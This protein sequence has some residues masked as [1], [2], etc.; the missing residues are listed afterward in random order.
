MT[1]RLA[2]GALTLLLL[3]APPI[4]MARSESCETRLWP[5]YPGTELPAALTQQILAKAEQE[6]RLAPAPLR[7]LTSA[8]ITDP[9]DPALVATRRA[10]QDADRVALLALAFH[11]SGNELYSE[12]ASRA[13]LAWAQTNHP[14][15]NPIDET[16]LEGFLWGFDQIACALDEAET[17]RVEAWLGRLRQAKQQWRFSV[18]TGRNNHRTHHLKMLIMLDK[19]LWPDALAAD[20]QL[21]A[22]HARDNIG[23]PEGMS[24]DYRERDALFY[25]AYNLEAWIEIA[26]AS[27]CCTDQVSRA[28]DFLF[29][30]MR[31]EPQRIEFAASEMPIDRARAQAGFAHAQNKPFARSRA[32]RSIFAYYTLAPHRYD[33]ALWSEATQATNSSAVLWLQARYHA[34][35]SR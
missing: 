2:W 6:S 33:A 9:Q 1:F 21:A 19:L 24:V 25:H 35:T 26:L 18:R 10:F 30:R 27:G 7:T 3:I 16:R 34:W 5:S 13:L 11:L 29:A 4:A 22:R 8:G 12:A 15:G 14:T 28:F 32:A 17:K 23:D 20:A 31:D